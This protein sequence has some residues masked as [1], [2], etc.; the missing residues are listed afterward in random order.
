MELYQV[1]Q[2]TLVPIVSLL[3][4]VFKPFIKDTRYIPILSVCIGIAVNLFYSGVSVI[5]GVQG[6]IIGLAASGLYDT[7]EIKDLLK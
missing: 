5:S 1:L 6:L 2:A 4:E 7:T 3:V